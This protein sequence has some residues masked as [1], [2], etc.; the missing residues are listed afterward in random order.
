MHDNDN[1]KGEVSVENL[2][3]EL[4]AGGILE[5]DKKSVSIQ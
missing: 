4:L 3:V 2:A 1:T 5:D